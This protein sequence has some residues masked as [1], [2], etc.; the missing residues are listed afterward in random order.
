MCVFQRMNVGECVCVEVHLAMLSTVDHAAALQ[1]AIFHELNNA[2][3][4]IL[5]RAA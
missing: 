5:L 2:L 3:K 4:M 1:N